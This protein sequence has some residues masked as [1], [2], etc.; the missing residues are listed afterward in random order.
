MS[1]LPTISPAEANDKVAQTYGRLTEM[2]G[3]G[4]AIP[5]PFLK[6]GNCPAYLQDFYMNFK[7]FCFSEGKIDL[8]LK[9][10]IGLAVASNGG[11]SQWIEYFAER[12]KSLEGTDQTVADVVGVTAACATYNVFFKF[13]DLSGSELFSG[14]AV[15]LRAHTFS[16]TTLDDKTVELINVAV[17]DV[18]GCKPC[19]EG[20]VTKARAMG[21][22][23]EALLETIQCAAT[24]YGGVQFVKA[25]G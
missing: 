23:D 12:L 19:T 10:I 4:V 1:L 20:H 5:A 16:A 9:A 3:E 25:A 2:F 15:G 21:I 7:K 11:S 14:M 18:N 24:V 17:S 8:K 22:S 6:L 13:R